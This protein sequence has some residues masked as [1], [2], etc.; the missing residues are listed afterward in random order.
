GVCNPVIHAAFVSKLGLRLWDAPP[1][2]G[3]EGRHWDGM[4]DTDHG[5][6][7]FMEIVA[8]SRQ[9][10]PVALLWPIR[11][12]N[13]MPLPEY[14]KTCVERDAFNQLLL[15]CLENQ[16]GTHF[17][18]EN[19]LQR[20]RVE[21]GELC[22]GRARYRTLL[23]SSATILHRDTLEALAKARASGLSVWLCGE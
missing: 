3:P 17:L 14:V 8:D 21:N 15:T 6:R 19:D 22:I 4:V 2:C 10:A 16:V 1:D 7:P 11:S 5:L 9:I 23:I 12:F 20:G 13:A 18:D